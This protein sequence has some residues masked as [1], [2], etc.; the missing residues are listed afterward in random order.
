MTANSSTDYLKK[1]LSSVPTVLGS[2]E[3]LSMKKLAL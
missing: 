1:I 3:L 2:H